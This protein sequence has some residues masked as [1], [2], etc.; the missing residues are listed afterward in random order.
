MKIQKKSVWC[1]GE[2]LI[3]R[4]LITWD[5][6]ELALAVPKEA[7]RRTGEILVE[8]GVLKRRALFQALAEQAGLPFIDLEKVDAQP[9]ALRLVSRDTAY[10]RHLV[11]VATNGK[12][13]VVAVSDQEDVSFEDDLSLETKMPEIRAGLSSPEDV[14]LALRRYYPSSR[15]LA[16]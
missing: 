16:A 4:G 9:E 10:E 1:I 5:E 3:Q 7:R 11:P 12:V 14:D 2:I 8:S 6:L 15:N 13:L